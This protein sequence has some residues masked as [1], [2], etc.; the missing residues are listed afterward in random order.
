VKQKFLRTC[1]GKTKDGIFVGPQ[2]K[3]ATRVRAF[4]ENLSEAEGTNQREF[5][6][7]SRILSG[8]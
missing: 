6:A 5:K 3:E 8:T 2:I 7:I 1:E 4:D